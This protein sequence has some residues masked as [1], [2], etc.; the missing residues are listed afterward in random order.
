MSFSLQVQIMVKSQRR[1][2][3]ICWVFMA[4]GPRL[5]WDKRWYQLTPTACTE[6]ARSRQRQEHFEMKRGNILYVYKQNILQRLPFDSCVAVYWKPFSLRQPHELMSSFWP[7]ESRI[8]NMQQ[9]I[10]KTYK[11]LYKSRLLEL[12]LILFLNFP[13][14]IPFSTPVLTRSWGILH[15]GE[16]APLW[17]L[18]K[19]SSVIILRPCHKRRKLL[20]VKV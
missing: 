18:C 17:A 16:E 12:L 1:L 13:L 5:Q 10:M 2:G 19:C 11:Y 7:A 9:R 4:E 20:S 3:S 14:L 8:S 6:S 15:R